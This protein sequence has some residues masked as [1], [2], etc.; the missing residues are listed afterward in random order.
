[1][2]CLFFTDG[3][4]VREKLAKCCEREREREREGGRGM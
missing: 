1:M 2:F 4:F 3:H